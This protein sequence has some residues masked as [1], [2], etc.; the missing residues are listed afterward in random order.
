MN[1]VEKNTQRLPLTASGYRS[2]FPVAVILGPT[3]AGKSDCALRIAENMGWEIISCD[4]RQIYRGMDIGTAKPNL[5]ELSCVRHWLIDILDPSEEYSAFRFASDAAN[6]IRE[7]AAGGK[8]ALICGGTGFYFKALSEG[9]AEINACDA[10]IRKKLMERATAEGAAALYRELETIDP[11]SARNIH[12]N[13]LHRIV[14]ALEVFHIT[15]KPFSAAV[16]SSKP[17]EDFRFITAIL[18]PERSEL[19]KRINSRVDGMAE[20]GLWEEFLRLR[21]A[22][23][24]IKSPGMQSVGYKELFEVE[25]GKI[26][27]EKAVELIKRNSR[28]YAKRQIT[29]FKHQTAGKVFE[30]PTEWRKIRD[31][32]IKEGGRNFSY[33]PS[34]FISTRP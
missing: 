10:K 24:D 11:V 4:S 8:K 27:F 9:L 32:F 22:G 14:R 19:Y 6:I 5:K 33:P 21:A 30:A 31:Y 18:M 26:S 15:G 1:I 13:N 7:L 12:P 20:R 17:P 25:E 16:A 2:P 29:W 34:H 3:G 23:Y 28:R